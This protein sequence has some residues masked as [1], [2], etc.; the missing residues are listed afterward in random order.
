MS[1]DLEALAKR[2]DRGSWTEREEALRKVRRLAESLPPTALEE[3]LE[4]RLSVLA[5]DSKWE[6]RRGLAR[7]LGHYRSASARNV[8]ERLWGDDNAQV[9]KTA[10]ETRRGSQDAPKTRPRRP[11]DVPKTR[12]R[13]SHHSSQ[14]P[15]FCPQC[16]CRTNL[17]SHFSFFE[18]PF[19]KSQRNVH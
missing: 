14:T 15:Q 5:A 19:A 8:I 12:P 17:G 11:Q 9:S 3:L 7:V 6:V 10:Q 18:N 4:P 1:P 16:T 13:R 2:L